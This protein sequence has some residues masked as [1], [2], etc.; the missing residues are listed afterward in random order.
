VAKYLADTH[1]LLWALTEPSRLSGAVRSA[2]ED[3]ASV[4]CY[5]PIS[6]WELS[7]KYALGKLAI[8]GSTPEGLVSAVRKS[9][10]ER[11]PLTDELLA[12]SHQLPRRHKDPFDRLLFWQAIQGG[13]VLLS[14]DRAA[15]DYSPDGL[16]VIG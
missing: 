6:L 1:I 4:P 11:A 12:S 5:S 16:R 14:S 8:D 10:L 2:L 15:A 9:F 3:T 13:Y 7:I